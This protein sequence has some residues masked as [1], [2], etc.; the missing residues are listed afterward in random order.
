MLPFPARNEVP[1]GA[2][3]DIAG[4]QRLQRGCPDGWATPWGQLAY[5]DPWWTQLVL[6]C[7][8]TRGTPQASCI[9][10]AVGGSRD[11]GAQSLGVNLDTSFQK[12]ASGN[13]NRLLP[14]PGTPGT[15]HLPPILRLRS[16]RVI[17]SNGTKPGADRPL[18]E[19]EISSTARGGCASEV[20][21]VPRL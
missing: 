16:C 8:L 5:Q 1:D 14:L 9:G 21:R 11:L 17:D 7:L 6:T 18:E 12:G 2:G 4:R 20:A 13:R 3:S 19:L 15:K 10:G